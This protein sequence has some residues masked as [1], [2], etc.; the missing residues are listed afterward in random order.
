MVGRQFETHE[1]MQRY[2]LEQKKEE[3]RLAQKRLEQERFMR[4]TPVDDSNQTP[5]ATE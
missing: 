1:E 4:K 2:Y 3:E 5:H